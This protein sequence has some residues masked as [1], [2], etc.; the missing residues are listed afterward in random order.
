M[1]T[2]NLS[3]L[4]P[5]E[6]E[7]LITEER[8]LDEIIRSIL[9]YYVEN[10]NIEDKIVDRLISYRKWI[11][12][13]NPVFNNGDNDK[14]PELISVFKKFG[15]CDSYFSE[16]VIINP[17]TIW[18]WATGKSRPSKILGPI[19][20]QDVRT[21]LIDVVENDIDSIKS[22]LMSNDSYGSTGSS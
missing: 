11:K 4:I 7:I 16:R 18:R 22:N 2:C 17:S 12:N 19:I 1:P 3:A 20:S 13:E 21:I 14:F 9:H 15:E 10:L 6:T 5:P 8:R